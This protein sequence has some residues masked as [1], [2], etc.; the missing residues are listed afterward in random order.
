MW[1]KGYYC[2]SLLLI[3]N[4][5]LLFVLLV[6]PTKPS[7]FVDPPTLMTSTEQIDV[8]DI[9]PSTY[10]PDDLDESS[11]LGSVF[12]VQQLNVTV[13]LN[14]SREKTSGNIR[15][16]ENLWNDSLESDTFASLNPF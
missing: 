8:D 7:L 2:I 14:E 5:S 13:L 9:F 3:M 10:S 15:Y 16:V 1:K 6:V 11:I 12:S 4:I